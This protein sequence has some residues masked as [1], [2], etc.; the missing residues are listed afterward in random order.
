M[1]FDRLGVRNIHVRSRPDG[2]CPHV[3]FDTTADYVLLTARDLE[4]YYGVPV[5]GE[6]A[7][8]GSVDVKAVV[9]HWF[10]HGVRVWAHGV[11]HVAQAQAGDQ[12]PEGSP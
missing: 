4:R 7:I 6:T 8:D 11:I 10:D 12:S 3:D 1:Q 9:D 5:E 2:G